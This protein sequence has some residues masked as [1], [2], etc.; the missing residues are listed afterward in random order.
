MVPLCWSIAVR[1]APSSRARRRCPRPE[2]CREAPSPPSR[3][4]WCGR[5][6]PPLPAGNDEED[7][8]RYAACHVRGHQ[9]AGVADA[10]RTA[11]RP[12]EVQ[13]GRVPAQQVRAA[14][15]VSALIR[16]GQ[17]RQPV[18]HGCVQGGLVSRCSGGA[19]IGRRQK[20][21]LLYNSSLSTHGVS[22]GRAAVH[23]AD[24]PPGPG[25]R[26][27]GELGLRRTRRRGLPGASRQ[28]RA[29]RAGPGSRTGDLVALAASLG[30][31]PRRPAGS[32]P[33]SSTGGWSNAVSTPAT[34]APGR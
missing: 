26:A 2:R 18:Y 30:V 5:S 33:T 24:R 21:T 4:S 32:L 17:L 7:R 8:L 10:H 1:T 23:R 3:Q 11:G 6:R 15:A 13:D 19:V 12:Q 25:V 14:Q 28:R 20:R 31:T 29:G 9:G 22:C 34:P 27:V 16:Q